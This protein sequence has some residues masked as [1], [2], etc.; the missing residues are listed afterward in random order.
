VAIK[1]EA[2]GCEV[3]TVVFDDG[4]MLF[5]CICCGESWTDRM[6]PV[7]VVDER[8]KAGLRNV[9]ESQPATLELLGEQH[10]RHLLES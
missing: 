3:N 8:T 4:N 6:S 10:V 5:I 2:D 1:H 9:I 7:K